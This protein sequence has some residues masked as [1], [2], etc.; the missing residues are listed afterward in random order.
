M[1]ARLQ[2]GNLD[3]TLNSLQY[4][5]RVRTIK[6]DPKREVAN[7]TVVNLR[8]AMSLLARVCLRGPKAPVVLLLWRW[9]EVTGCPVRER[10]REQIKFWR[11]KAA[12]GGAPGASIGDLVEITDARAG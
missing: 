2:D 8:R 3:E 10:F 4:A 5:T 12:M 1:A 7:K 11:E 6:N 9:L